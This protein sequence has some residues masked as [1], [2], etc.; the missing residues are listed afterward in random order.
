MTT[1]AKIDPITTQVIRSSL[2]AAAEEMRIALV[3]TAYN[4]LIY[5]IQDF[6]VALLNANGDMLAQG[7]SLPLFLP[8]LSYTIRNGVAKFG[9]DGFQ[10]DDIIIANDPY[11]TGTHISDTSIYIPIFYDGELQGFSANTAHWADIGGKV[12]GGWCPDSIDVLQEGMLFR[13]LKLYEAGVENETLTDYIMSNNRFPDVVRGD[14]GAQI[15]ACKTGV[16][17]YIAVCDKYGAK[18]VR[19]AME[20]VFDQSEAHLRRIIRDIPNGE[21]SAESYM[22][23]DGVEKDKRRLIKVTVKVEDDE[24]TVDF[25]GSSDVTA[26]PINI[27]LTGARAAV[28]IAFK[29]ATTPHEPA[30]EGHSRPLKVI[31]PENSIVNP[32]WPAPCDSYGYAALYI[33]DL[34]SEALSNAVPDRCPAGEY[35]LFGTFMFRVDPRLGKPFIAIDPVDGGGGALPFDDGADGLIFHGDGD[36][37]NLPAE[38]CENRWPV[39]LERYELNADE[40]G[41]GKY[42]GGMGCIRE[43]SFLEDDILIQIA[44]EQTISKPHGLHGGHEGGIN[45]LVVR[46]GTDQ[47][48]ILTERASFFGPFSKGEVITCRSGG[49]GG[50]GDPLDRDP[51]RVQSEV[52]NELLTADQ[53]KAFYGVI[54]DTNA[55]GDPVVNEAQTVAQR[56][57]M[58][59]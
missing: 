36:V 46:P 6:A 12:P 9:V 18:A 19:E 49:G 26:G 10:P 25:T 5:E 43:Y 7:V 58:R 20:T 45:Y 47:E 8:C 29:S 56:A 50:Y 16:N 39:R 15:A 59:Q 35:M 22:D 24:V 33:I 13:H 28:E 37:P 11:S 31:A 4:P 44:N 34:V 41:I 21:W 55:Q 30:N 53:A 2:V 23:H 57:A 40:Y 1:D 38:V 17:R 51:Q 54:I 52:L 14:L 32:A 42:R 27:P 48:E 3:Q